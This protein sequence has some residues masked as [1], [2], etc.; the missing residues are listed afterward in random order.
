MFATVFLYRFF[1]LGVLFKVRNPECLWQALGE[2]VEEEKD[3]A[4]RLQVKLIGQVDKEVIQTIV[5]HGLKDHVATSPYI[6]HD[7]VA[8]A[9]HQSSVLLLPL[10][11][12]AETDTL[13]LI[14]AKLFEYMASGRPILCIGPTNGDTAKILDETQAGV[15]IGFDDKGKAKASVMSLYQRHL[16]DSLHDKETNEIARFSRK[17]L[18]EEYTTLLGNL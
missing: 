18:S 15:T 5:Q 12:D 8:E 13:G 7:Q 16:T 10:M 4:N 3:F 9:L 17:R 2:L 6:P 11:S 14:P 1:D